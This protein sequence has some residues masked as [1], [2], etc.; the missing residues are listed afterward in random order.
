MP[1]AL[2][3]MIAKAPLGSF[4]NPAMLAFAVGTALVSALG[5]AAGRWVFHRR[6]ADQAISSMTAGYVNSANLGIPVAVQ[7][8]GDATF[9]AQ[10][11]L[12]QVLFVTP[13]ILALI[14]TDSEG[15]SGRN[16]GRRGAGLTRVLRLP[17]RNPILLAS[18]L[19]VLVSASGWQPPTVIVHPLSL[20]GGAGVPTAL[21][22]LGMS[23]HSRPPATGSDQHAETAVSV[24]LKTLVQP[25]AALAIAGPVLHLPRHQLLAVV[26]CSALPTA[27]N[28]FVYARQYKLSTALA[29]DSVMFSTLISMVTLSLIPLL[30]GLGH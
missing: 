21:V 17:L 30:L 1:A 20:L 7:V 22:T 13:V 9:I 27:Q 29:R 5:F 18:A 12:F 25:L 8:L 10:V 14:D 24:T 19:G 28:A 2:F 11:L 15:N 4:A 23:L 3:T 6:P 16:S 26:L